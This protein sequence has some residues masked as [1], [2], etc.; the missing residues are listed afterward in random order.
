MTIKSEIYSRKRKEKT[1]V[2]G[3]PV[4]MVPFSYMRFFG[5]E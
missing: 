5:F 4:E 3:Y 2:V 1:E